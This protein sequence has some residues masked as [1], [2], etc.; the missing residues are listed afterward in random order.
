MLIHLHEDMIDLTEV[1]YEEMAN[2][3]KM[4]V[5]VQNE[6]WLQETPGSLQASEERRVSV[7]VGRIDNE[8]V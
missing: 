6:I 4:D 5:E 3:A 8:V 2:L 7:G 1:D